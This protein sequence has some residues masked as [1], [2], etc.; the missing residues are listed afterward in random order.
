MGS[1]SRKRP[2]SWMPEFKVRQKAHA[3]L[4]QIG[5]QAVPY[6]A[7]ALEHPGTL[8]T[9]ERLQ[10][11]LEKLSVT[12]LT[13]DRLRVV[14]AVEVLER[15][16]NAEARQLLQSLADGAPGALE[17]VQARAALARLK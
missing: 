13:G 10:R 14:R 6:L 5:D 8:E 4:V 16:S 17:T 11:L 12:N 2:R 9:R 15:I 1:A 3:E 7:K